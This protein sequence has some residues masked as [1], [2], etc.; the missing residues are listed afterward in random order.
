MDIP[1]DKLE[2]VKKLLEYR[3]FFSSPLR[4]DACRWQEE[5]TPEG[6]V[7]NVPTYRNELI[8][9]VETAYNGEI[10][11]PDYINIMNSASGGET[12]LEVIIYSLPQFGY[13]VCAAVLTCIIRQERFSPGLWGIACRDG[14]FAAVLDRLAQLSEE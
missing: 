13:D 14:W 12:E 1:K 4:Q 8:D 7:M 5:K 3:E 2:T 9:F 10:L 11:E 6:Q